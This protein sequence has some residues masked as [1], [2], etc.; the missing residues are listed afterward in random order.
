MNQIITDDQQ[1]FLSRKFKGE[2]RSLVTDFVRRNPTMRIT[3]LMYSIADY[4]TTL[5]AGRMIQETDRKLTKGD[6]EHLNVV[7]YNVL[8]RL[9]LDVRKR[10]PE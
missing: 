1:K 7:P 5:A 3:T 10:S 8:D 6:V 9:S 4:L 2:L